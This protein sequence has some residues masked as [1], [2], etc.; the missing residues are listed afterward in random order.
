[1]I[2]RFSPPV[3]GIVGKL[4]AL[5]GRGGDDEGD[6]LA[7]D[8]DDE[9]KTLYKED[10]IAEV[11]EDLKMRKDERGMLEQQ[12]TLNANFL[13]GN[14]YC[15]INPYRGD[16]E[17]LKPVYDWMEHEAFNNIAVLIDTRKANLKKI[18]YRMKV[19]P[20]TNELDDY[21][22]AEVSTDILQYTQTNTDFESK[23]NMMIDWNELCGNVFWMSW[24]DAYK[25]E[26]VGTEEII[27]TDGDGNE[28]KTEKAYYEGDIDYGLITPYELYPESVFKETIE[29]QRSIIIEQVKTVDDVYDLYGIKVDGG[30]VETFELT[31]LASSGG[32]GRENTVMTLG[33]RTM[34]NAVKVITYMERPSKY[35]PHGRMIIIVGDDELVYYGDLPYDRIPIVQIKC[36]E[37][38]GQFYGKSVIE[39]LI[40]YQRALNGCINKIHEYIKRIVLNGFYA[41]EGS[42]D[43]EEY[44]ANGL[45][46]GA[47]MVYSRDGQPPTPI[48]NGNLPSEI[49]SERY[50]LK[51]DMEYVAGTSQLMVNGATPSG[52]TSGTAIENLMEIDNTR[53]SMTGDY[54]RNGIRKMAI[55]WLDIY[56]RY[57]NT[58]R[59]VRYVGSNDIAKA[60]V[61]SGEDINSTDV[62]Y[63]TE[64]EL[65]TSEEVQKQKFMEAYSMGL[66]ADENGRV[67]ERV[68]NRMLECM[69]VGNYSEILS[70][71][72]LHM[73]AAQ[74][75]NVFFEQ[76][77]MP[78]VSEF[79]NHE[80]H[81][82]E[83]MRYILQMDFHIMKMKK[84]EWAAVLESHLREHQAAVQQAAA[85]A[86]MAAMG[87]KG[88]S[89]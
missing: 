89:L 76:G 68:K 17:Q 88:D 61:W 39:D 82:E 66:F 33:H 4:S 5:F 78:Q 57:A 55:M 30:E 12:W 46:P 62:E 86:M 63:T 31:P 81:I 26:I 34:D 13:V 65:L 70:V 60:I 42:I 24:W 40:P 23:R 72:T 84:P 52:V 21:A 44:E 15:D 74:R 9:G 54:I 28:K 37:I 50:N 10:I 53:L 20:R 14:Q 27:E 41:Q 75:E 73:Q 19:K 8:V 64:N 45:H 67:S 22:K 7:I 25:G 80:I 43:I 6:N 3:S 36:R 56:K 1:M 59:V 11:F 32:L 29:S 79:D 35:R 48:P 69:K 18:S 49:M 87:N 16:I 58:Q 77:V 85:T 83:H 38:A 2:M 71:N 47:I 51:T